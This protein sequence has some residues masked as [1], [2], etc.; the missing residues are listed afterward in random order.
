[1]KFLEKISNN[2][3]IVSISIFAVS[4][5]FTVDDFKI[6]A[7]DESSKEYRRTDSL[8]YDRNQDR[9]VGKNG[10]YSIIIAFTD[11]NCHYRNR[12][13][14]I[15][16]DNIPVSFSS[17]YQ[18]ELRYIPEIDIT[19]YEDRESETGVIDMNKGIIYYYDCT[20]VL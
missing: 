17:L 11:M 3:E 15:L 16:K 8:W 7:Y 6:E 20:E 14:I 12:R 5:L 10:I 19:L 9:I 4:H 13:M 18:R 1:M 2:E